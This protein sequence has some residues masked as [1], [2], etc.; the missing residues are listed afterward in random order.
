MGQPHTASFIGE[1]SQRIRAEAAQLGSWEKPAA[2]RSCAFGPSHHPIFAIARVVTLVGRSP[3]AFIARR[4]GRQMPPAPRDV[5]NCADN[6][7]A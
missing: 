4:A 6:R 2:Q 5:M 1:D 3:G 7:H